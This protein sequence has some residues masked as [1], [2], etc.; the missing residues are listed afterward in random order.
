MTIKFI[1]PGK[2]QGKARP[3][4]ANGHTY[5]PQST[6]DYENLIKQSFLLSPDRPRTPL[7]CPVAIS[8]DVFHQIPANASRGRT[9][10]LLKAYPMVKPDL[11]NVIKAVLDALNGLAY[12]DDK[13]VIRIDAKRYYSVNARVDVQIEVIE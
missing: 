4:F 5:T 8:V 2:P 6:V 13:Q 3:R 7:N 9:V 10:A 12:I 1:V 11:D